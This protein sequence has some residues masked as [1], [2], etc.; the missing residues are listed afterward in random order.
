MMTINSYSEVAALFENLTIPARE[1]DYKKPEHC[2]YV[3]WFR[4]KEIPIGADGLTI[5]TRVLMACELYTNKSDTASEPA[6]EDFFR[7]H[8]IVFDKGD[9][10]FISDENYYET[11][12]EFEL[13]L[14]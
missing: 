14:L 3:A 13:I 10:V 12:Y 5:F 1:G 2:P 4:S 6:L 7:T 8:D 9:R 11:V